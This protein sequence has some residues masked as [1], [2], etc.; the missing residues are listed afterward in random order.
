[1]LRMRVYCT[2]RSCTVTMAAPTRCIRSWRRVAQLGAS[3]MLAGLL[4]CMV[5]MVF[6][7]W[8]SRGMVIARQRQH[9]PAGPG[10]RVYLFCDGPYRTHTYDS[11]PPP[12]LWS[13]VFLLRCKTITKK[14]KKYPPII[15]MGSAP[16]LLL[17]L[18]FPQVQLTHTSME[19][20]R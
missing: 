15:S 9:C 7:W 10:G 4:L 13:C 18:D 8:V 5:Q 17:L 2:N 12:F 6:C 14:N 1:M 3:S 20:F 11:L 19:Y 16:L